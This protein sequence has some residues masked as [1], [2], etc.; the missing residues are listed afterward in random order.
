MFLRFLIILLFFFDIAFAQLPGLNIH[1]TTSKVTVDGI[2]D[3]VDWKTAEVA[4]DFKQYFPFDSSYAKVAT[5]VRMTYDDHFIYLFAIMHNLEPRKYVTPSLRRDFRG[6]ANDAFVLVL[7]TY[8]DNT[9]AFQFGVNPFGVQREGLV[10]N[11]GADREDLSSTCEKSGLIVKSR[12]SAELTAIFAS[13]PTVISEV[14]GVPSS[15]SCVT[16]LAAYGINE[17]FPPGF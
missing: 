6:E 4:K 2:M 10:S 13:P 17:I 9:N 11:G 15:K 7:D 12:L 1:K 14:R 5:E 8:Q 16:L 3:D